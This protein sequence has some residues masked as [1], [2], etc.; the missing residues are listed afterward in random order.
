MSPTTATTG[1]DNDDARGSEKTPPTGGGE[2]NPEKISHFISGGRLNF[3]GFF[4]FG[5][6]KIYQKILH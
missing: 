1:G 2:P 4:F 6:L 3:Y 5:L